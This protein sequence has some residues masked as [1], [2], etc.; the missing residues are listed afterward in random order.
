M[1]KLI[2]ISIL[3][4]IISLLIGRFLY[5]SKIPISLIDKPNSRKVHTTP[6]PLL[7]GITIVFS[8][9]IVVILFE[10]Y[11][12]PNIEQYIIFSL[13]FFFVGLFDDLFQLDFNKKLILQ[14]LGTAAFVMSISSNIIILNF[15]TL[16]S[17]NL[18]INYILVA[19]WILLIINAFNF[20]DGINFLAGSLS[21]VYFS[22]Y[23]IFYANCE[24][25]NVLFVLLIIIF[26]TIG[27]LI[28][29]RAPAKMFLGDAGSMFLGFTIAA[30]PF[31]FNESDG[32]VNVAFFILVVFILISDTIFV[33]IKRLAK[34]KNPF[35]PDKTH[36]HHQ[37]LY[38]NFRNRY[39]VLIILIGAITHSILAFHIEDLSLKVIILFIIIINLFFILFPRILPFV[40]ARYNLWKIKNLFDRA[41]N[42]FA[43]KSHD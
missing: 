38:L 27:F 5:K 17:H 14:M 18:I 3:S 10:L 1:L 36:L 9:I 21:I 13:Y 24:N 16:S 15:S 8:M 31:I 35:K 33:V 22:T 20:F 43:N 26:S 39:V 41:I 6:T 25:L 4:L 7:G 19:F 28:Y 29:N 32:T 23:Y 11:K 12:D 42:H 2:S 34:N 37:L 30:F 40:F